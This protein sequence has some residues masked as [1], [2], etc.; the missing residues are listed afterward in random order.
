MKKRLITA[1]VG[2]TLLV[3]VLIWRDT[4]V[5]NIAV[6][7]L[8]ILAVT[9]LFSAARAA[10]NYPMLIASVL[11][12]GLVPF[13]VRPYLPFGFETACTVYVILMFGI[14]LRQHASADLSQ[15]GFL[16]MM[17]VFVPYALSTMIRLLDLTNGLFYFCFAIV[18][19]WVTDAGA[20]FVGSAMGKHKLAPRLSP[21]KTVEGAIG[22]VVINL[23]F[24]L[25][26]ALVYTAWVQPGAEVSYLL[27]A[28]VALAGS[29][30]SMLGDLAASCLK[31]VYGI[32]DFGNLMPGHGG[33]MDRFDSVLIV[34]PL[35]L[36]LSGYVTLIQ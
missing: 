8:C 12:A 23:A 7:L 28:V 20:Y 36:V 35:I 13:L 25:L 29:F 21:H 9:E 16:L 24:S 14:L 26:F 1:A 34:A 2:L 30:A 15:F 19:A 6:A 17:S 10:T 32:K 4:I 31:R 18:C 3:V 22:G 33:V 11:F 27:L 5:M